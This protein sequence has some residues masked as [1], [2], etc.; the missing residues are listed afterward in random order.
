[1]PSTF[2]GGPGLYEQNSQR[3]KI[4]IVSHCWAML[5]SKI[6]ATHRPVNVIDSTKKQ[7][8]KSSQNIQC[9]LRSSVPFELIY[10][11]DSIMLY[12]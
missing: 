11:T 12:L 6:M 7:P 2:A 4:S 8:T 3:N 1:M 10:P 5:N 9:V